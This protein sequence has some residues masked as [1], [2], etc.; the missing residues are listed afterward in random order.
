MNHFRITK[1]N[2]IYRVDGKYII[3][4]WT[5]YSDI[6]KRVTV[7]EYLRIEKKYVDFIE[8]IVS[9]L[10]ID[11]FYIECYEKYDKS[12]SW[13]DKQYIHHQEIS[14]IISDVLR[15][16]CWC[17]LSNRKMYVH[18]GWDYYMYVGVFMSYNHI[19]EICKK[20]DLFCENVKSPY[21][22]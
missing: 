13:R 19:S 4:E 7:E 20:Y 2:P 21:L 8:Y 5:D 16:K 3:D 14:S 6:G 17:K 15:N 10:I 1:Y 22:D 9:D 11:G 12:C 18:F